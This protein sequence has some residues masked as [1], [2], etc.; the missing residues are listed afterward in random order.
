MQNTVLNSSANIQKN[1]MFL[2]ERGHGKTYK[3]MDVPGKNSDQQS[4]PH[5]AKMCLRGF[6]PG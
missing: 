3:M 4:E 5:H 1:T 6:R 2:F